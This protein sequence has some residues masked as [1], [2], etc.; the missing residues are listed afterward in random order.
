[1]KARTI[2]I[3]A[4]VMASATLCPCRVYRN[5]NVLYAVVDD[6]GRV[7]I[8]PEI[9]GKFVGKAIYDRGMNGSG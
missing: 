8:E 1:M 9:T 4:A 2:A 6:E 7:S 3:V 5:G